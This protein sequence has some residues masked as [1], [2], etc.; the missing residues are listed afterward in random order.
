[1]LSEVLAISPPETGL[2]RDRNRTAEQ[3]LTEKSPAFCDYITIPRKSSISCDF[4]AEFG[5][6]N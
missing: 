5:K 2:G 4:E 3:Q 1:M 6:R